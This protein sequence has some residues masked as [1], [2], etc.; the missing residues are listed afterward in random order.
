MANP[1]CT[2]GRHSK[3]YPRNTPKLNCLLVL[4]L[5]ELRL[6]F[7]D[8]GS[9]TLGMLGANVPLWLLLKFETLLPLTMQ[10]NNKIEI[11]RFDKER[12]HDLIEMLKG[13]VVTQVRGL[14]VQQR[15]PF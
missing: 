7:T 9:S 15:K 5:K 3:C 6:L 8:D 10:E 11:K 14:R 13:F 12:R 4:V 1:A 2:H